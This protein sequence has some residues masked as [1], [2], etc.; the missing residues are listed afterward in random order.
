MVTE[1][2]DIQVPL[3]TAF[4]KKGLLAS[5]GPMVFES[6][7]VEEWY[8]SEPVWTPANVNSWTRMGLSGRESVRPVQSLWFYP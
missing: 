7:W 6:P 2:G 5:H 8:L 4:A 1:G 3:H